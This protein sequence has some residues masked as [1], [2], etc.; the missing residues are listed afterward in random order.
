[1]VMMMV[2][3]IMMEMM[4]MMMMMMMMMMVHIKKNTFIGI[5]A[6]GLIKIEIF[7]LIN[8]I[9]VVGCPL[10]YSILHNQSRQDA[11]S[12]PFDDERLFVAE[13]EESE[14]LRGDK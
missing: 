10:F 9:V 5:E 11:K 3:M 14:A 7:E 2:I 12:N 4:T 13:R 6:A 1:M 8:D